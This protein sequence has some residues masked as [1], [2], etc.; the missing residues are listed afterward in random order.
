MA[1]P[2]V[3]L[4]SYNFESIFVKNLK[5]KGTLCFSQCSILAHYNCIWFVK[6]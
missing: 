6:N 3:I 1:V 5:M 4:Q 2:E